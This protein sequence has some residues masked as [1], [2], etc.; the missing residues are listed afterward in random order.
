M[1]SKPVAQGTIAKYTKDL[2][3]ALELVVSRNI[4]WATKDVHELAILAEKFPDLRV[5]QE[6]RKKYEALTQ[7]MD[8]VLL[9][10]EIL[11]GAEIEPDT[12][13]ASEDADLV[14]VEEQRENEEIPAVSMEA[15]E[16][17]SQNVIPEA[18]G[19]TPFL[20][21]GIISGTALVVIAVLICAVRGTKKQQ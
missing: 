10:E 9:D 7:K 8:E 6:A 3:T 13:A 19:D 4:V 18:E 20:M 12:P 14:S 16:Q 1:P 5:G 15:P 17:A 11:L 2:T 21:Y